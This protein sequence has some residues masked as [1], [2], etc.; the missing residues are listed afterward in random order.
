M[1]PAKQVLPDGHGV[2]KSFPV[3]VFVNPIGHSVGLGAPQGQ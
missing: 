3:P 2:H 1:D